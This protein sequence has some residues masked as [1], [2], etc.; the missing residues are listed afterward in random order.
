MLE[1]RIVET[2]IDGRYRLSQQASPV[3]SAKRKIWISPAFQ[4]ILEA[5]GK[6]FAV[7]ELDEE[8]GSE[9]DGGRITLLP[10]G[11]S[12]AFIRQHP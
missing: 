9:I 3:R 10:E 11:Q 12:T 4:R 6:N 7:H 8:T 2:D 5:S 1:S